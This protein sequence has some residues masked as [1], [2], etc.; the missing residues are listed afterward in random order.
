M[1]RIQ[2]CRDKQRTVS[3]NRP[4]FFYITFSFWIILRYQIF[5]KVVAGQPE[6]VTLL[7]EVIDIV[8]ED[9]SHPLASLMETLGTLAVFV[10]IVVASFESIMRFSVGRP[11]L[12]LPV[13][14]DL[15]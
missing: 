4:S 12:L 11:R 6:L 8:G 1:Q 14:T 3:S 9:E 2:S 7:D 13:S 5:L 15:A 10:K